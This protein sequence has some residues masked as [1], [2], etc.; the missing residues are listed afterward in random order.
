MKE[1][2]TIGIVVPCFN[3]EEVIGDTAK[4][5]IAVLSD[6]ERGGL[7]SKKS[8]IGF[9]D[10]GSRDLTW[11]LIENLQASHAQIKG[12]KL[13]RNS[14]HQ[15]ALLA[16]LLTFHT[17]ADALIS[18][19]ADLQD[20]TSA[21]TEMVKKFIDGSEI[22][23]GV[24][25]RRDSDS[26]FKRYSALLFYHLMKFLGANLVYN[27]ADYRLTSRR[28]I[29]VLEKYPEANLFLRGVFPLIGFSN[30]SVYYDRKARMAGVSKYPFFKMLSFAWEGVTSFSIKP[31]RLV[32]LLGTFI[33]GVSLVLSGYVL[34]SRFFLQVVPGWT[35]IVLPIYL[36]GG[37]QLLAIGILGEYLGKIYQEVKHRPRFIIEKE[38]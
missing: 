20:D 27:H 4:T 23:Y 37:I 2:P 13:A 26:W 32:T 25:R 36:L 15:R 17:V 12:L 30:T 7:V 22:V 28:V 14:G 1:K 24:R 35:S 19:D 34:F 6:L 18:I 10:D 21:I 29:E 11:S 3:E 38:I 5:L 31:L 9:I 8:F 16:G 33:F